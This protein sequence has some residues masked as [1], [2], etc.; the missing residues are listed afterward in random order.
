MSRSVM[1]PGPAA[2]GSITT[3]APTLRS[4][5]SLAAARSVCPG[6]TERTIVLIP[7]CTC[8]P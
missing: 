3:A 2:S 7:S 6:P 8:I 1:M 4:A 5:I